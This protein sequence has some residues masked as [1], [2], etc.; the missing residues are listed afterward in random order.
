MNR[1]NLVAGVDMP[2]A[3]FGRRAA[4]WAI[5]LLIVMSFTFTAGYAMGYVV[6]SNSTYTKDVAMQTQNIASLLSIAFHF[7]YYAGLE[8]SRHQGTIGKIL[9][10]LRVC[11]QFGLPLSTGRALAHNLARCF[12]GLTLGLGYIAALFTKRRQSLHDVIAGCYVVRRDANVNPM[13][14]SL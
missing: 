6:A 12:M 8:H 13:A 3:S 7:T 9:L 4:A 5:D 1:S 11:D 10:G 14:E 2:Y